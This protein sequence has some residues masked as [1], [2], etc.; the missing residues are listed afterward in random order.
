MNVF[1]PDDA[2]SGW[3]KE[4][5][6]VTRL[7]VGFHTVAMTASYLKQ[8]SKERLEVS[9]IPQDVQ[10]Q[11]TS[12][13]LDDLATSKQL[14]QMQRS[15]SLPGSQLAPTQVEQLRVPD[16]QSQLIMP[17][18]ALPPDLKRR[19]SRHVKP[20]K[21]AELVVQAFAIETYNKGTTCLFD[22]DELRKNRIRYMGSDHPVNC[23]CKSDT[24]EVDTVSSRRSRRYAHA[25]AD[26]FRYC[27]IFVDF[28]S[29]TF[30]MAMPTFHRGSGPANTFVTV[31]SYCPG[32]S[33]STKESQCWSKNDS[34][35]L[36]LTRMRVIF[37]WTRESL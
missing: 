26:L 1:F 2:A 22:V 25:V 19:R 33:R 20:I 5:Q 9:Q 36:I 16:S 14:Q 35:S 30:A 32:K 27:V 6:T 23:E 21:L 28:Y 37:L 11:L 29:M 4:S 24:R 8:A 3:S 31:V 34:F 12:S 7:D 18:S 13:R 17:Q 10:H 15:S